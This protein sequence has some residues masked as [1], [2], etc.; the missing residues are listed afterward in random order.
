MSY[1]LVLV[2]LLLLKP[3]LASKTHLLEK[4]ERNLSETTR[5][6]L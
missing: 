6:L 1:G 5:T 3:S 4:N 2:P